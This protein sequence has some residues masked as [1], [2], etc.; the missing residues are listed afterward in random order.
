MR[1]RRLRKV[2]IF[3]PGLTEGRGQN[4]RGPLT[5]NPMLSSLYGTG[6]YMDFLTFLIHCSLFFNDS[7]VSTSCGLEGQP[8][9]CR[10]P[11]NKLDTPTWPLWPGHHKD[12]HL[13]IWLRRTLLPPIIHCALWNSVYNQQNAL[14]LH[15]CLLMSLSSLTEIWLLFAH[16]ASPMAW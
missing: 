14:I 10:T 16:R 4:G 2:K 15:N 3:G 13:V 8:W 11:P 6:H 1:S 5:W 12:A 9:T 7:S